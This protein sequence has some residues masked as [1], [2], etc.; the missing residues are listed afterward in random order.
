MSVEPWSFSL[1]GGNEYDE[2]EDTTDAGGCANGAD[3]LTEETPAG[4]EVDLSNREDFAHFKTN[5]WTIAKL[6]AF[7]R[8]R[9]SPESKPIS[10]YPTLSHPSRNRIG[11]DAF[12]CQPRIA[13]IEN[14][15]PG[16]SIYDAESIRATPSLAK[17]HARVTTPVEQNLPST[18]SSIRTG[19]LY[20]R[21]D[22]D[23]LFESSSY[24][25]DEVRT[26]PTLQLGEQPWPKRARL[27]T[28]PKAL[29]Q[30]RRS[31]RARLDLTQMSEV[32]IPFP[33][34]RSQLMFNTQTP[35]NPRKSFV[36]PT[37][38]TESLPPSL[39]SVFLSRQDP[40]VARSSASRAVSPKL[41]CQEAGPT[42]GHRAENKSCS[43][44]PLNPKRVDSFATL[45]GHQGPVLPPV[46]WLSPIIANANGLHNNV[47]SPM[48]NFSTVDKVSEASKS[49]G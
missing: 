46:T 45:S 23:E 39:R 5:P 3:D 26:S 15:Q 33:S 37:P 18:P 6:N 21:S 25:D 34:S 14:R 38:V 40:R 49:A 41:T 12:R 35:P 36:T 10:P 13:K 11:T 7:N 20:S 8:A 4:D 2:D 42:S 27:S 44:Q 1:R 24:S 48:S 32:S 16:T 28:S 9:T 22:G 30:S 31:P 47:E 17:Q 43:S 19:T 29:P